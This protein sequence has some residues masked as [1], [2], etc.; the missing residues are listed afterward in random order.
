MKITK[1]NQFGRSLLSNCCSDA[2]IFL[3]DVYKKGTQAKK[4]QADGQQCGR[5]M[6][7]MLGVLAIIG[8]LSIGAI[9]GYS[10]AMFKYKMNKTM[11][12]ISHAVA[13]IVELDS[14]KWGNVR[15]NGHQDMIKYGI[16]SD[17]E[18]DGSY[19]KLPGG[20]RWMYTKH[21][22]E[23]YSA[24]TLELLKDPFDSCVAFFN[25][26]IF[27]QVPEE[28][29]SEK[30]EYGSTPVISLFSI[31]HHNSTTLAKHE[32]TA[33]DV[34]DACNSYCKDPCA[35]SWTIKVY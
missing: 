8:V 10:K 17:C 32:L 11:D 35:V 24:L 1:N 34:L 3:S 4:Y 28:W 21:E 23:K 26:K 2:K 16:A 5:S 12:I 33:T 14:M 27:N 18:I 31:V 15:V 7:E 29:W 30:S 9:A 13:R 22:I 25:S 19:C 20:N 6:V